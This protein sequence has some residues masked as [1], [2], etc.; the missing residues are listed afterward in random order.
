MPLDPIVVEELLRAVSDAQQSKPLANRL[1]HW[2]ER[3]VSG[4]TNLE[5]KEDRLSCIDSVLNEV[6][7]NLEAEEHS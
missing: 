1:Q 6:I 5:N 7:I 2:L 4:D 3:L